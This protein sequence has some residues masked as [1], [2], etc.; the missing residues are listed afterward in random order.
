MESPYEYND[1]NQMID[2]KAAENS[3]TIEALKSKY[4]E[5]GAVVVN[6]VE[7]AK[8]E[9]KDIKIDGMGTSAITVMYG[10]ETAHFY[11]RASVDPGD[12]PIQSGHYAIRMY[13][14]KKPW[15]RNQIDNSQKNGW[16]E[17]F[18]MTFAELCT[19]VGGKRFDADLLETQYPKVKYSDILNVIGEETA[20]LNEYF[21]YSP[22]PGLEF[23]RM[24]FTDPNLRD[25]YLNDDPK[26][27]ETF[28]PIVAK[29]TTAINARLGE[30][31]AKAAAA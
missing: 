9:N 27:Y 6:L 13:D 23:F 2:L 14:Y 26:F 12:E 15:A 1:P 25:Q 3:G 20:P 10:A 18:P 22:Q 16:I 7:A 8:A 11:Y 19:V 5:L 17:I 24:N 28:R 30:L 29:V 4:G 21:S 31:N